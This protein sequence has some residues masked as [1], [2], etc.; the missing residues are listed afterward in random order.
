MRRSF[1]TDQNIRQRHYEDLKLHIWRINSQ[2]IKLSLQQ[3]VLHATR[4]VSEV[5]HSHFCETFRFSQ[6]CCWRFRFSRM[7]RRVIWSIITGVTAFFKI[8]QFK[9]KYAC[10]ISK[11]HHYVLSWNTSILSPTTNSYFANFF[12]SKLRP[13]KFFDTLDFRDWYFASTPYNP[14]VLYMQP[15]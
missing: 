1:Q 5:G 9:K 10:C 13:S 2:A 8:M 7:L 12:S 3:T 4:P 14:I 11:G 15:I 6:G